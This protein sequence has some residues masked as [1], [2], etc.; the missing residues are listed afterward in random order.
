MEFLEWR[1]DGPRLYRACPTAD[2][3]CAIHDH[4][5]ISIAGKGHRISHA[6]F[7]ECSERVCKEWQEHHGNDGRVY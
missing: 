4:A 6:V 3:V 2:V 1:R 5:I 7:K